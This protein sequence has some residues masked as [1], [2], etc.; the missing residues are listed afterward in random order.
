MGKCEHHVKVHGKRMGKAEE[1]GTNMDRV[2]KSSERMGKHREIL[3]NLSNCH[4]DVKLNTLREYNTG[5]TGIYNQQYDMFKV[6]WQSAWKNP[7]A[8]NCRVYPL[9]LAFDSANF[10]GF[11]FRYDIAHILKCVC[12]KTAP[13]TF[14]AETLIGFATV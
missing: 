11:R 4:G 10:I 5:C 7:I 8:F 6:K 2:G 1:H 12:L 13:Q 14:I 3:S 9:F